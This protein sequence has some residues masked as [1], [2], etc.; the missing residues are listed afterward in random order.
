MLPA[1][2]FL[3][4]L[5]RFCSILGLCRGRRTTC[6]LGL[7]CNSCWLPLTRFS[8]GR[9]QY[10]QYHSLSLIACK[11]GCGAFPAKV[12]QH[13]GFASWW[14]IHAGKSCGLPLDLFNVLRINNRVRTSDRR[15][16]LKGT[17]GS[18]ERCVGCCLFYFHRAFPAGPSYKSED[19][20][21]LPIVA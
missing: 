8:L 21:T 4:L 14:S 12:V 9:S 2:V 19:P 17:Y 1:R 11:V 7:L 16:I 15:C 3:L 10:Q 13:I 6:T 5:L 20:L 18:N